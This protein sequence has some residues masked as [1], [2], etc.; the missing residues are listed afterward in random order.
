MTKSQDEISTKTLVKE[1]LSGMMNNREY[2]PHNASAPCGMPE[3]NFEKE[4]KSKTFFNGELLKILGVCYGIASPFLA[5]LVVSI[6]TI[7]SEQAVQK[8]RISN[9]IEIQKDI[10]EIKESLIDL[11]IKVGKIEQKVDIK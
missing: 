6:F 2:M 1:A 4:K 5:W 8:E 9:V 3:C 7:Q 10:K 11:R